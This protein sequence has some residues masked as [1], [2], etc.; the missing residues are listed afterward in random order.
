MKFE[1]DK[2]KQKLQNENQENEEKA[3]K[4]KQREEGNGERKRT[5]RLCE[6]SKEKS[7]KYMYRQIKG[8]IDLD[9]RKEPRSH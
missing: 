3:R 2:L 4:R 9:I 8:F 1:D 5:E 6:L 7:N